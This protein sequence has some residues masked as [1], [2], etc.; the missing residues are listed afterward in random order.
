MMRSTYPGRLR[1]DPRNV[2][3]DDV[4]LQK[5]LLLIRVVQSLQQLLLVPVEV[6][7]QDPD[8][9]TRQLRGSG[10]V[11][12]RNHNNGAL[13]EIFMRKLIPPLVT[14]QS[15]AAKKR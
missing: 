2:R 7:Q 6:V 3:T 14:T 11:S 12:P 9:G 13:F 1:R 10:A 4:C 5:Q 8:G 15:H